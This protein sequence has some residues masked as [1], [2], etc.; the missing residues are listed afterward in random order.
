MIFYFS[1]TGN[2]LYVAQR[3]AKAEKDTLI[4]MARALREG[5]LDFEL[6]KGEP[7]GFVFPTYFYT[8]PSLVSEFIDKLQL[9]GASDQSYI[10]G[11]MTCGGKIGDGMRALGKR[12]KARGLELE[13]GFTILMPDN[14]NLMFD[15]LTPEEKQAKMLKKSEKYIDEMIDKIGERKKKFKVRTGSLPWLTSA[16]MSRIYEFSR[17]TRPFHATDKCVGCGLCEKI[18]PCGVIEI[19]DKKPVWK[20][21]KC[22]Q[23]LAC[24]HRCPKQAIQYGKKTEKRGRYVNPNCSFEDAGHDDKREG[25]PKRE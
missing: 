17:D 11:V 7:V 10:Y 22:T 8:V 4:S 23:C 19:K 2:S 1:G 14:Y 16:L 20:E 12:L 6:K 3:I 18:C 13:A 9:K 21:G 15:L 24:L 5:R 25:A